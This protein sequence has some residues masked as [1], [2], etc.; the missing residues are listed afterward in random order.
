MTRHPSSA[1]AGPALTAKDE[2]VDGMRLRAGYNITIRTRAAQ[3]AADWL[4]KIEGEHDAT[5]DR[6][7]PNEPA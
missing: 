3:A 4:S 2:A 6:R 5:R 7:R 1:P